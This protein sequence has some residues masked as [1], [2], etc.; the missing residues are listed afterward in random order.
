MTKQLSIPYTSSDHILLEK[1]KELFHRLYDRRLL[2]RLIGVRFNNLV[3]GNYQIS[4]STIAQEMILAVPGDRQYQKPVR[5]AI[6]D[7]RQQQHEEIL[8][9]RCS[10]ISKKKR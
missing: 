8:K 6:P 3:S 7:A 10:L 9:S 2:I 1:V 5:L 4:L